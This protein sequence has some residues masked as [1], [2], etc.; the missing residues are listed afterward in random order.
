MK[1]HERLCNVRMLPRPCQIS[2]R[3]EKNP[4]DS[5]GKS[6]A[7]VTSLKHDERGGRQHLGEALD[8]GEVLLLSRKYVNDLIKRE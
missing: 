5:R 3:S 8:V 4:A 1:V 6:F 7:M 2:K